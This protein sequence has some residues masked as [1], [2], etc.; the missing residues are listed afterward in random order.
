MLR[1]GLAHNIRLDEKLQVGAAGSIVL[2][3][4]NAISK[5]TEA[6]HRALLKV[7]LDATQDATPAEA[8][9][10]AALAAYCGSPINF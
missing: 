4:K 2:S 3:A 7:N 6:G 9:R 1:A 5:R 10:E 8:L